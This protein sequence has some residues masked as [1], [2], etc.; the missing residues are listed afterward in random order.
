MPLLDRRPEEKKDLM[1]IKPQL[2]DSLKKNIQ[3]NTEIY[4]KPCINSFIS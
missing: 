4:K 3:R 2:E 1:K